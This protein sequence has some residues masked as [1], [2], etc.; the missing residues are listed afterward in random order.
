[1]SNENNHFSDKV[2]VT[3]I[4]NGNIQDFAM[5]VKSTEKLVTQ[6]V[7]KM[8]TN[9]DDQMDL[10]QDIYLKAYQNL[11]SFKFKSKLSTWI[12]NI[13]YNTTV[14]Y[15]Q[16]KRIPIIG[17]ENTI[18]NNFTITDNPELATIKT[19]AVE[20]LNAEIDKLPPLHKTLIH[21]YHL[22]NLPIK[23]ISAIINLPEGTI[24]SYLSRARKTLKDNINHHF[25]NEYYEK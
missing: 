10:V 19:E 9:V 17:I 6:V 22:E 7:R 1:M 15:L 21:L 14:N 4:L 16:K 18:E 13:A 8:T 25:K 2:I 12:A 23:E 24:K 3:N 20:I 11:P 5:I